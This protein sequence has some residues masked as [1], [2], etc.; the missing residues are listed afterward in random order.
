MWRRALALCLLALPASAEITGAAYESPTGRYGHGA[1]PGGEYDGLRIE[2]STGQVTGWTSMPEAVFEDTAPRLV[3]LDGDGTPEVVVVVSY[4]QAGAAIRI[5]DG[6][7]RTEP[8][9]A[10]IAI[11]AETAPIGTRHRWLAIAGIADLDADGRMEIA[12]VDRPHLTRVLRVIE[13]GPG[14]TLTEEAAAEG[15]TNH[16]IGEREISGGVADCGRG[17]EILTADPGWARVQGTRLAQGRLV[18]RDL[19]P[20]RGVLSCP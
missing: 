11:V 18:T 14:W 10:G 4:L 17:P 6:W 7:S 13:V 19:G 15:H 16:R 20:Y 9:G 2:L 12:Y 5:I 1:V 3:D 8:P